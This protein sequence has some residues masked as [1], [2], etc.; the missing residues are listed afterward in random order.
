VTALSQVP[1]VVVTTVA[2]DLLGCSAHGIP[3]FGN[4]LRVL[5]LFLLVKL[6]GTVGPG[7]GELELVNAGSCRR[8]VS[9]DA[10]QVGLVERSRTIAL[11]VVF[12]PILS[13]VG[14]F[15]VQH[16]PQ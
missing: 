16:Q 10:N 9:A 12:S 8:L 13:P 4:K 11:L 15:L 7:K 5:D 3:I 2:A 14:A 1:V 6:D